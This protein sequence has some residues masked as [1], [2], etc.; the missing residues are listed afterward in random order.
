METGSAGSAEAARQG[1]ICGRGV[2]YTAGCG[3]Y[4]WVWSVKLGVVCTAGCGLYSWVWS[5]Q[6]G[7]V[8][9]AGCGLVPSHQPVAM[10]LP[11][12]HSIHYRLLLA[13]SRGT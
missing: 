2:V 4:S 1:I 9:T 11:Y 3:L 10:A 7:V 5:V 13:T 6:L 12:L 8:C